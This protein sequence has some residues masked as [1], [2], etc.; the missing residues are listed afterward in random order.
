MHNEDSSRAERRQRTLKSSMRAADR[1]FGPLPKSTRDALRRTIA[2]Y[3]LSIVSGDLQLIESRWYITHTGLLRIA[4]RQRC[5]G[6]DTRPASEFCDPA[7]SR[8]AFKATVYRSASCRGFVGYGDADPSNVAP[9]MHGAEM[10]I[11]ETRAVNRAL[12]KAYAV[13]ICSVEELGASVEPPP[14]TPAVQQRR[15]P[16]LSN[17]ANG[18]GHALRD[19]L[20]VV[21][22]QHRLDPDLVKAYAADYCDVAELKQA[23]REQVE[24]FVIHLAEYARMN[25]DELLCQLNSYA[26]KPIEA[27]AAAQ[28][29][30]VPLPKAGGAA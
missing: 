9:R 17:K 2:T 7:G 29:P 23:T 25:R 5:A 19:R 13:G 27:A 30:D 18:N 24:K 11:A 15:Q 28:E 10:R 26:R 14:W 20:R 4:R 12:R 22:R 3:R 1:F 6:I 21:I 16:L 8:W